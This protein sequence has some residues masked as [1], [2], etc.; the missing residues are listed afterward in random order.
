[1]LEAI[2]RCLGVSTATLLSGPPD[3]HANPTNAGFAGVTAAPEFRRISIV[4]FISNADIV[5]Y[6]SDDP[7]KGLGFLLE[8]KHVFEAVVVRGSN[9]APTYRDGDILVYQKLRPLSA[10]FLGAPCIVELTDGRFFLKQLLPGSSPDLFTLTSHNLGIPAIVDVAV[11]HA[12]P[13]VL[14]LSSR[15]RE[16]HALQR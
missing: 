9:L 15:F 7:E 4:G 2:A 12:A 13:I 6:I 8:T 14:H 5:D 11:R 1:M 10:S 3:A 16:S